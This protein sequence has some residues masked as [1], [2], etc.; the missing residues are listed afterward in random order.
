MLNISKILVGV[1]LSH[2]DWRASEDCVTPSRF[3]CE[4]AIALA[5]AIAKRAGTQPE[6]HFLAMLDLD[7]RSKR[8]INASPEGEMTALGLAR[9]A[10]RQEVELAAEAG[11][12]ANSEVVMGR[13]RVEL[14]KHTQNGAADLVIVGSRGH[15]LLTG[16]LMG[17][18][19]MALIHHAACPVWVAKPHRYDT[20]QRILVAT[21]FSP[22]CD[23]LL[24]YGIDLARWF[25]AELHIVHVVAKTPPS[26]LQFVTVNEGTLEREHD[27]TMRDA[28]K[29]LEAIAARPEIRELEESAVLHLE[30][31]VAN[32]VILEKTKEL[33]IDL[34]LMGTVAWSGMSGIMVGSTAQKLLPT[35][36]CSLLTLRESR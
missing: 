5:A 10:I 1:D 16:M 13:P 19:A 21:D 27:D 4:Q 2:G 26:F 28:R 33:D 8:L 24:D 22:I 7:E 9:E 25:D 23:R 32:R 20:P 18:T 15:G 11:V 6:I 31:G 14:V 29:K 34:L 35:L 30:E 3:A 17:S 12:S 36:E